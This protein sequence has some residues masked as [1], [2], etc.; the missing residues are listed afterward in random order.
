ME[1]IVEQEIF[2]RFPGMLLA[3]AVAYGLDN[4]RENAPISADW[5][6]AWAAAPD[7]V[8][9]Y[10]NAQSHPRIV[11]WRERFKAMGVSVK[12]FRS[13]A[14]AL[15]RRAAKGGEPFTINPLVD[16]YNAVSL[17]HVSPAGAF[18]LAA[19]AGPLELRLTRAGD[20]FTPLESANDETLAL[21]P[22]EVAYATGSTI[23]TRHF[24]WRQSKAALI[25]PES[26]DVFLVS[27]I[28]AELGEGAALAIRDEFR[29]GLE[30]WFDVPCETWIV[31]ADQPSIAWSAP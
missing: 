24:V 6:A 17:R 31:R 11:P 30:R 3:V 4:S 26:R 10:P 15:L 23:L 7:L 2:E 13:S 1:F 19:M 28:L 5:Q 21:P 8:A 12:E 9:P 25:S 27:E 20:T 14:E 29:A 22:G 16:F 18:D